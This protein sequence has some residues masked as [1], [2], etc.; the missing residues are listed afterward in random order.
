MTCRNSS[1]ATAPPNL[2]LAH[3]HPRPLVLVMHLAFVGGL[4]ASA[5]WSIEAHAQA[6]AAAP[7]TRSYDIPAG[8]LSDVLTRFSTEAGIF[9]VGSSELAQGKNSRGVRGTYG[10]QAALDVLLAGTGL[11]MQRNAQGRYVLRVVERVTEGVA[12]LPAVSVTAQVVKDGTTEGTGSYTATSVSTATKLNLSPRETP[13]T[14]TVITRQELDDFGLTTVDRALALT[15]GVF[16]KST[17][18]Y[19]LDQYSRGF[20]MQSQYDGVMNP[21]GFG[22]NDT[23]A[24]PDTAF[25][26]HIEVLQ[27]ASGLLSGAGDPGGVV[28]MVFKRPTEYFQANATTTLGS[29]NGRRLV[30]DI[31]GPLSESKNVRGRVVAVLDDTDSWI[32]KVYEKKKGLY[33]V[34]E[35]DVTSTTTLRTSI[36]WQENKGRPYMGIPTAANG[37]DLGFGRS[38]YFGGA[39]DS[40]YSELKRYTIGIEQKLPADWVLK[41][42]YARTETD[43]EV[44]GNFFISNNLNAATGQGMTWRQLVQIRSYK[45][46]SFDLYASG[47]F[48]L[49]DR[50]HELVIGMNGEKMVEN[51][52]LYSSLITGSNLINIY[53]FDPAIFSKPTVTNWSLIQE[54]VTEQYGGFSVARLN[55]SDRL[56][57]I[58]GARITSYK[59]STNGV[60][61]KKEDSQITPY[62]GL[63]FDLDKYH[64]IYASY[65]DIFTPQSYKTTSGSYLD[66]LVGSNYEAGVK[67]A[68][69]KGRLHAAAAVFQLKQKN[70]ARRDNS[71]AYNANNACGGY[72][73]VA[74]DEL[75]SRGIDLSLSGGI[76]SNWNVGANFTYVKTEYA[77]GT[78]AGKDYTQYIPNKMLKVF[79]TYKIPTTGWT[80]GGNMRTQSGIDGATTVTTNRHQGGI[81]LFG[82]LAK[83]Q[84][85]KNSQLNFAVE[86]LFDRKYWTVIGEYSSQYGDPRRISA[87]FSYDF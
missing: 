7:A 23:G 42:N 15:S 9:L 47:P 70:V 37:A 68:Y 20:K 14:M 63:L 38:A 43:R 64:T 80:V 25:F 40:V 10:V 24:T 55:F 58:V 74:E 30:G 61:S 22:S 50:K 75:K 78:N 76:T 44:Y 13:Q 62:G 57:A 35:A 49:F 41:A 5:G 71:I 45:T 67:G 81:T 33:G 73:Y 77:S 53:K 19:G 21:A 51:N 11:E 52:H 12:T 18:Y 3:P 26:D 48:N 32:D 1:R 69:F 6:T 27:G 60:T 29:W 86:N 2:L 16:G 85:N 65:T 36:Q 4:L 66:P 54:N 59:Y 46:D 79:T 83:Y 72:C 34:L 8:P 39:N 87:N 84:I 56:K 17:N 28:N 31:S 82:M